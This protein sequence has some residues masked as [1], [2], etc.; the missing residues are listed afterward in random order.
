MI[1]KELSLIDN[2]EEDKQLIEEQKKLKDFC[3]IVF[4]NNEG[5]FILKWLLNLCGFKSNSV[6]FKKDLDI[7]YL[8]TIYNE[9]RRDLYLNLRQYLS[10]ELLIKVEI[11]K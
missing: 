3:N 2:K 4:D 7:N 6:C 5:I 11:N 8:A 10:E 1:D 9:G